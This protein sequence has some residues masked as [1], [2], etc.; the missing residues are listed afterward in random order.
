[1]APA[2]LPESFQRTDSLND[3]RSVRIRRE[4][5]QRNQPSEWRMVR[6]CQ[7]QLILSLRSKSSR[8]HLKI[9]R[10]L[11]FNIAL[12]RDGKPTPSRKPRMYCLPWNLI[13]AAKQANSRLRRSPGHNPHRPESPYDG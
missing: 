13:A 6:F 1:V 3:C 7:V 11:I 4:D 12:M 8:R 10:I 2:P 9:L 5:G